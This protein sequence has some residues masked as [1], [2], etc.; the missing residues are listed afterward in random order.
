MN[1]IADMVNSIIIRDETVITKPDELVIV[2]RGRS[3]V[4][5]KLPHEEKVLKVFYPAYTHLAAQEASIY[6][7]LDNATYYP[8]LYEEGSGYLVLEYLEGM[9]LYDC[10]RQGQV[11]TEQIIKQVDQA[12]DYARQKD[13]NPSDTHLQNV[14]LLWNGEV[15]VIDVVR[16]R[17]STICTHWDDLKSVY[18]DYY[19]HSYFPKKYPKWVIET[20]IRLYRRGYIRIKKRK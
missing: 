12:L 8:T 11:I 20:I 2:G 6:H 10:L 17:Q 7:V 4:V 3:A 16:F 14:M 19:Q 15:R 13:L 5:F 9:T 1:V 18:Y